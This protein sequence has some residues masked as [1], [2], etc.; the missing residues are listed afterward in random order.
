M[1]RASSWRRWAA[2]RSVWGAIVA[3]GI[4]ASLVAPAVAGPDSDQAWRFVEQVLLADEFDGPR[5]VVVRWARP[6]TIGVVGATPGDRRAV[7][8]TVADIND[9]LQGTGI[10]LSFDTAAQSDITVMF[11]SA[12]NFPNIAWSLGAEY[13]AGNDG[14]FWTWWNAGHELT[15]ARVVIATEATDRRHALIAQEIVQTLGP[16]NDSPEFPSSLFYEVAG[17]RWSSATRLAPIDRKLLRFLYDH[18]KA[19]DTAD[20]VRRAFDQHWD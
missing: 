3:A 11:T 19:G 12:E 7:E 17:E 20:D 4:V 6:P 10:S 1:K 5:G 18:L 8:E 9:A 15:D 13:V 2:V 14:F 16:S